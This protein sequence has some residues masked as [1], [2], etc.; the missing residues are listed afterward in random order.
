MC[1][2]DSIP[3]PPK[4]SSSFGD[5]VWTVCLLSQ[6]SE[7]ETF[8]LHGRLEHA[9]SAMWRRSPWSTCFFH[10]QSLGVYGIYAILGWVY[11]RLFCQIHKLTSYNIPVH[12]G[13]ININVMWNIIWCF[14][15][16]NIWSCRNKS[17]FKE[18]PFAPQ[19]ILDDIMFWS[20]PWMKNCFVGFALSFVQWVSNP[21]AC[22]GTM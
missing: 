17:I 15:L 8:L 20:L 6:I 7:K 21:N 11:L 2:R 22:L 9:N 16:W 4:L 18:E 10:V 19:K 13:S 3:P 1:I 14:V 5:F 12:R